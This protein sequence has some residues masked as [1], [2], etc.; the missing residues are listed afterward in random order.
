MWLKRKGGI[1]MPN[2]SGYT[3]EGPWPLGTNFKDVAGAYVVYT[4]Q[5]WLDVGETDRLGQRINGD[6]H[7]RKPLW[8]NHAGGYQINIAFLGVSDSQ[9]RLQIESELRNKLEPACGEK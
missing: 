9:K 5:K 6:N 4:S 2:I 3:F 8:L 7:E 1:N